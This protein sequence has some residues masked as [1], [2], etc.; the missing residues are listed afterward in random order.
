MTCSDDTDKETRRIDFKIDVPVSDNKAVS[1]IRL[2]RQIDSRGNIV[3]YRVKIIVQNEPESRLD[4]LE[5]VSTIST[6]LGCSTK[7]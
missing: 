1:D 7:N 3:V 5:V 6:D 4:E 2:E